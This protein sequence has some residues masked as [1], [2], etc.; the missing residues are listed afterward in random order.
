MTLFLAGCSIIS[1]AQVYELISASEYTITDEPNK[2]P[3]TVLY[4]SYNRISSWKD[5]NPG[6]LKRLNLNNNQISS[7]KDFNPGSLECLYLH[8]N[9]ISS[10]KDFNPGSLAELYLS[11]NEIS[12]WKDFNPGSIK[13]LYLNNNQISSWK[14]FNPGSKYLN[15]DNNQFPPEAPTFRQVKIVHVIRRYITR[16]N[17]LRR[18]IARHRASKIADTLE[19][20]PDSAICRDFYYEF[21]TQCLFF[22]FLIL[23]CV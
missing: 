20:N 3:L 14:D 2:E 19:L 10:W 8:N 18:Y 5:F 7:W 16:R 17:C 6:S 11:Y 9:R 21:L 23:T 15:L 1:W 22:Y 13:Y 4:L 12:S